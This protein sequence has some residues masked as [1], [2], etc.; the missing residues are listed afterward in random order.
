MKEDISKIRKESDSRGNSKRDS[1]GFEGVIVLKSRRWA[2]LEDDADAK[3]LQF[4][5]TIRPRT[6]VAPLCQRHKIRAPKSHLLTQIKFIRIRTM[7]YLFMPLVCVMT[8][9][10]GLRHTT[11]VLTRIVGT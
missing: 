8:L 2:K 1:I 11:H 7:R 3:W 6:P 9:T 4:H 10:W 5:Q